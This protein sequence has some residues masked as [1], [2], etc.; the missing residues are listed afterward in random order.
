MTQAPPRDDAPVHVD[1]RA[2]MEIL[3]AILLTIFL[4]AL[5]QTVVG[6]ALPRIVT[7]LKGN[8]LYVWVVTIYLLTATVTGP[9][10]GKLSDQF[11]RRPLL[12]IGVSLFLVGSL[13]SGLSQEMWQ[14]IAARGVQGLGAGAIFPIALA[15]IGDLFSPRERGKYQGLFGGVFA[16]ASIL[17][18]AIGG[19]LTDTI[20]WH[21]VFLV[22]LPLGLVALAVLWRLLPTVRHP[23]SVR[24]IDYLGAAVFTAALVPFLLG[25]TNAQSGA[26]SDPQVGGLIGTGLA[27]G[28]LFI[29]VESRAVQPILPLSLFRNRTVTASII[30]TFLVTFGFFGSV[31]FIP[32]WFQFVLGSSAT[33]SGYQML[34]LMIGV[35]SSSIITGQI[36]AR[37]GRYKWLAVGAMSLAALGLFLMTNLRADTPVTTVWIWMAIA[38]IGI[39]PSF[40]IF[41]IVVQN[42]VD[43]SMLGAVSSALTFFRQVGGSVG[44][45]FAG[46]IFGSSLT[47]ELPR[48]LSANG[49]PGPLVDAFTASGASLNDELVGVGVDLEQQLLAA[50]PPQARDAIEPFLGQIADAVY[51]AF[52]IAIANALWLGLVAAAAAAVI[53]AIGV[54]ELEL[55]QGPEQRPAT[56]RR[57]REA[58][59][60]GTPGPAMPVVE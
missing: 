60:D 30:A 33:E 51:A 46:A 6:T 19:F 48:Q 50:A 11:G 13:L 18:P 59:A 34:P 40:S 38:G 27:I 9:I 3:G 20:S 10:Y 4:S 39:G 42:A 55:R 14:L 41:T 12:M 49:V 43:R 47:A 28:A 58:S 32:R 1:Q 54:P 56:D 37:T 36:V 22:N 52:S 2:R 25:L 7:D 29:W 8:E 31:I 23:E 15:V 21:W 57:A 45:A 44:L 35:M 53:V 5:D 17:G 16:L 24:S 26:W